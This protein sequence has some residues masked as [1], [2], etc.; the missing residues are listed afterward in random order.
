[1]GTYFTINAYGGK[2]SHGTRPLLR[3]RLKERTLKE[4][5]TRRSDTGGSMSDID[6]QI[7]NVLTTI[8]REQFGTRRIDPHCRWQYDGN[9][10]IY[11]CPH[12]AVQGREVIPRIPNPYYTNPTPIHNPHPHT[13]YGEPIE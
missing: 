1:M 9:T 2:A 5:V 6:R 13:H 3:D 11:S 12:T 4:V 10:D 8:H 7:S